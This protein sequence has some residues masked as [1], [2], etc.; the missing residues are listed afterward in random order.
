MNFI[1]T[2]KV[3]IILGVKRRAIQKHCVLKGFKKI[4]RDYL[5]TTEQIEQIRQI[6]ADHPRGRPKKEQA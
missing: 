4:G 6:M 3:A 2:D 5:L 1:P